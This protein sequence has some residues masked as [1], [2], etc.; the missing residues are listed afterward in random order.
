M[1]GQRFVRCD[2]ERVALKADDVLIARASA[3]LFGLQLMPSSALPQQSNLIRTGRA[4]PSRSPGRA[5]SRSQSSSQGTLGRRRSSPRPMATAC[6][7]SPVSSFLP[8]DGHVFGP[9][10]AGKMSVVQTERYYFQLRPQL[11]FGSAIPLL[12]AGVNSRQVTAS[13][14]YALILR[15]RGGRR[16]RLK[17]LNRRPARFS[18]KARRLR[19]PPPPARAL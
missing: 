9:G 6:D 5:R 16:G 8:R 12:S 11:L 3:D 13:G 2:H 19:P 18:G 14:Q 7:A 1:A 17:E 4:L 10:L 15:P